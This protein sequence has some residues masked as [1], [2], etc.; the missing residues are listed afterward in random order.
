M[1]AR[2][3]QPKYIFFYSTITTQPKKLGQEKSSTVTF[4]EFLS[5]LLPLILFSFIYYILLRGLFSVGAEQ[6]RCK[7]QNESIQ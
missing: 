1:D 3:D 5:V 7:H 2:K 6:T 4:Q